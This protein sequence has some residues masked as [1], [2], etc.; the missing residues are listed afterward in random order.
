MIDIDIFN[1]QYKRDGL[2][3]WGFE[4]KEGKVILH[5]GHRWIED[6][7]LQIEIVFPVGDPEDYEIKIKDEIIILME[8]YGIFEMIKKKLTDVMNEYLEDLRRQNEHK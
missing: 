8:A 7:Y 5:G 2:K 1:W 6:C 3:P 4:E